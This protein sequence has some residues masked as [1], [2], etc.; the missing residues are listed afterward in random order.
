M[1]GQIGVDSAI[2]A[3]SCFWILLPLELSEQELAVELPQ[4]DVGSAPQQFAATMPLPL[5]APSAEP[6]DEV[7][8]S[9]RILV[10]DDDPLNLSVFEKLLSQAGMKVTVATDGGQAVRLCQSGHSY[11]LVLMDLYMPVMDGFAAIAEIRKM[12]R[13]KNTPVVCI[14]GGLRDDT[15]HSCLAAGF[16]AVLPKPLQ[17]KALLAELKSLLPV[18]RGESAVHENEAELLQP[19][20]SMLHLG[21]ISAQA[22]V[23]Q[24]KQ[25][26]EDCMG[27]QFSRF[28][29]LL[30]DFDYERAQ[31]FILEMQHRRQPNSSQERFTQ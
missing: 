31:S 20:L 14:S 3:G 5:P 24:H 22:Y 9:K 6:G 19:L 15:T 30:E 8:V 27:P 7:L 21:D 12:D 26:L 13:F 4:S 16:T 23:A 2:G 10:V 29:A 18:S 28:S 17:G 11:A 1:N 25:T